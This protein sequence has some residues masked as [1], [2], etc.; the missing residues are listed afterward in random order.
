MISR[1]GAVLALLGLILA[2]TACGGSGPAAGVAQALN[3]TAGNGTPSVPAPTVTDLI[4][5]SPGAATPG[6]ATPTSG[7]PPDPYQ[8]LDPLSGIDVT[9]GAVLVK[10]DLVDLDGQEPKR[11]LLTIS[12]PPVITDTTAPPLAHLPLT[13]TISGLTI[14]AYSPV[15]QT[16]KLSYRTPAPGVPGRAMP[17]PAAAQG[18]NLLGTNPPTPIL[19]LRTETATPG[20]TLPSVSLRLYAWRGGTVQ[21]IPMRRPG[22]AADEDAV[23]T[24]AADVQ[25]VDLDNDGRAEVVVDEG[26]KTT[27]WKWDGARFVPR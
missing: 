5:P 20:S 1:I 4:S 17:L 24:G 27:I 3:P 2:S 26:T 16:W 11:A 25:V 19:Q 21:P 22:A 7:P 18:R 13:G 10:E 8:L 9:T 6:A 14:L 23:F 15:S 12:V